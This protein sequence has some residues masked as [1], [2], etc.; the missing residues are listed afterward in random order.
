MSR[1]GTCSGTA[2]LKNP[3]VG[4]GGWRESSILLADL[5]AAPP[6]GRLLRLQPRLPPSAGAAGRRGARGSLRLAV[7]SA[8]A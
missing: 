8:E 4:Q 1:V 2:Q 6:H 7:A 3:F 5:A